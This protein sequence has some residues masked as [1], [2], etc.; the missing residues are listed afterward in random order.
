MMIL[1]SEEERKYLIDP[2]HGPYIC[3]ES[4]TPPEILKVLK[5]KNEFSLEMVGDPIVVFKK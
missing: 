1:F 5:R 3:H 4:K 2:P